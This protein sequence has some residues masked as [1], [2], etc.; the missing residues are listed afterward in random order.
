MEREHLE[1]KAMVARV[2]AEIAAAIA[3]EEAEVHETCAHCGHTKYDKWMVEAYAQLAIRN[4]IE[5][6]YLTFIKSIKQVSKA[7]DPK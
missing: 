7:D 1:I 5:E 6:P 3:A 4:E 2:D